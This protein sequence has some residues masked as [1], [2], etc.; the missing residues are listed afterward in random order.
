MLLLTAKVPFNSD[1]LTFLFFCE[2]FLVKLNEP[3]ETLVY[4]FEQFLEQ[5]KFVVL[6]GSSLLPKHCTKFF[7][8]F[9]ENL[10]KKTLK[11]H[12]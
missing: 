1:Y 7:Y 8:L 3:L 12:C 6:V 10:A 5:A 9:N 11:K 4:N 2:F